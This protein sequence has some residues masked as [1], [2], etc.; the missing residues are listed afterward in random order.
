MAPKK[1]KKKSDDEEMWNQ[2]EKNL[3]EILKKVTN[4]NSKKQQK[5]DFPENS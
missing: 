1:N 3:Q 2:N 5:F 4:P